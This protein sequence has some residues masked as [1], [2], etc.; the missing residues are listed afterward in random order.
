MKFKGD[1]MRSVINKNLH[2]IIIYGLVIGFVF[3]TG[4]VLIMNVDILL[5]TLLIIN[6]FL[7]FV[8]VFSWI[9]IK[10]IK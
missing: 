3:G 4:V 2:L 5:G 7:L 1:F 9:G 10:L 6:G 8:Y